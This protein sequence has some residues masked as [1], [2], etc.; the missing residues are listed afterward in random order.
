MFTQREVLRSATS[1]T[2]NQ[3]WDFDLP[4]SGIL[5][6]LVLY[7]RSTQNGYPFLTA[8]KWRLIDYISKIEVVGDGS[9]IIK[10]YDGRQAVA[11][12]FHDDGREPPHIWQHYSNS[13][14]RQIIPIHFGRRFFDELLGLDLSRFNQVTLKIT[15]DATA[16]QYTTDIKVDVVAIWQREP[17]GPPIGYL[18]EE[19]WKVWTPVA[20]AIEYSELPVSLPIRRILLRARPGV[21]TA[22][23]KNNSSMNRLLG[24]IDFTT[25]SGQTRVYQGSGELLGYLSMIEGPGAAEVRGSIDRTQ[26]YGFETGVGYVMAAGGVPGGDA[27]GITPFPNSYMR[28]GVNESAQ[29]SGRR[30]ATGELNWRVWG[31][32]YMHTIPLFTAR[33]PDLSDLLDPEAAK[34]VQVD[35][36]CTTGTTVS[37]DS[38]AAETAI[39]LSRLVR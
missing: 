22:D 32:G 26:A 34:Q 36:E 30:S 27:D 5:D 23:C 6:S 11:S 14:D 18:R 38:H 24:D 33:L 25:R 29:E 8:R 13:N 17:V 28:Q 16:T 15:N 3:T 12:A 21:D 31:F 7:I 1:M 4:K 37:G 10:S 2:F 19:E 20:A 39:I 35:I 9:I